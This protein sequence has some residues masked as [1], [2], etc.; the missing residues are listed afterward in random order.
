M[1]WDRDEHQRDL[2]CASANRVGR[3]PSAVP[4]AFWLPYLWACRFWYQGVF[5]SDSVIVVTDAGER[6]LRQGPYMTA[7]ETSIS[8][9]KRKVIWD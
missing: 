4:L 5:V 9:L 7:H 8:R 3:V 2:L 1:C 6:P